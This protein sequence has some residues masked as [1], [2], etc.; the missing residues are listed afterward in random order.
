MFGFG[1]FL[2]G[3]GT[4]SVPDNGPDLPDVGT[5]LPP[6]RPFTDTIKLLFSAALAGI[7]NRSVDY[8]RA[9]GSNG[10]T[11]VICPDDSFRVR[12]SPPIAPIAIGGPGRNPLLD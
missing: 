7:V 11:G 4:G 10:A 5:V 1:T 12:S 8:Y 3:S 6:I 9:R 2:F